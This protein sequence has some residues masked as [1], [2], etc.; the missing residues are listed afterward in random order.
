MLMLIFFTLFMVCAL[1]TIRALKWY[2]RA[3]LVLKLRNTIVTALGKDE[4]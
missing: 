3:D 2:G 1:Q 4:L